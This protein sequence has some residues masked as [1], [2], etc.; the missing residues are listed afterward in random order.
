MK[1][2]LE[3]A[4]VWMRTYK[5]NRME[6]LLVGSNSDLRNSLMP[7]LGGV[8]LG[9]QLRCALGS[10]FATACSGGGCGQECLYSALV[11]SPAAAFSRQEGPG[12]A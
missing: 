4:M 9:S 1:P 8:A 12:P 5:L 10:G 3:G 7:M 6:V 2:G 11:D